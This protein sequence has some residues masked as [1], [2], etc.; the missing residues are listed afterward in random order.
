MD[1]LK[2]NIESFLQDA[3]SSL[4]LEEILSVID[5]VNASS[6]ALNDTSWLNMLSIEKTPPLELNLLNLRRARIIEIEASDNVEASKTKL[7]KLR[8]ILREMNVNGLILP[9]ADEHQGEYLPS[10]AE[11]LSW[12]TGF[13]GSAG[14][15]V[16][17]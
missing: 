17:L 6:L 1:N 4:T 9:R 16:V 7:D 13:N 5:G 15:V 3:N 11:R 10:S 14:F 12:L 8:T 2:R